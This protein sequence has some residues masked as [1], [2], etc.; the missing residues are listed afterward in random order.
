MTDVEDPVEDCTMRACNCPCHEDSPDVLCRAPERAPTDWSI[1]VTVP[2]SVPERDALFAAVANTVR[3]WEPEDRDGWDAEI[4]AGPA[5]ADP[6]GNESAALAL[7]ELDA[8]H[9]RH[10]A[11]VHESAAGLLQT[12]DELRADN[13]RLREALD[14]RRPAHHTPYA[15]EEHQGGNCTDVLLH[16]LSRAY[17][18]E[19]ALAKTNSEPVLMPSRDGIY[20]RCVYCDSENPA[21]A[22]LAYSR[23]EIPCAAAHSCGRSLPAEYVRGDAS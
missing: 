16:A 9:Q 17:R 8:V 22:V 11:I 15:D 12:V 13:S 14:L 1:T 5:V 23:R 3:E 20:P 19:A 10:M 18:A 4:V 6:D 7:A 21:L 2:E